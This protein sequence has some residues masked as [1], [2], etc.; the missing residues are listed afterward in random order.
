MRE[1]GVGGPGVGGPGVGGPGVG[2]T[3]PG[4]RGG[5]GE[6]SVAGPGCWVG[7]L[8]MNPILSV[9]HPARL[10]VASLYQIP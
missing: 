7:C 6:L 8:S 1:T 5:V 4:V 10:E 2:G 3:D 9:F